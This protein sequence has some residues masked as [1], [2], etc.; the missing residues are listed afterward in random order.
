MDHVQYVVVAADGKVR[1]TVDIPL[2][3]MTMIHDMSLT[4][5]YAVVYDLPVTVDLDLA[6]AGRFP[7]RWNPD[8]GC[9]VGLLP[10]EGEA[11]DI[12]WIDVPLSY[13]FHPMNAYDAADGGVVIDLC[14][15]D[16]MF[17][18]D[19]LGPFGDGFARLERWTLNPATRTCQ[20]HR[21]RRRRA[22]S[23]RATAAR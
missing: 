10:R 23:S 5:R 11:A 21:H 15:Y 7:F 8:Y 13:S 9:R 6:F 12:V 20:R 1:R 18:S 2:P 14:V 19:I 22:P 3:G 17:D 16:R 4:Q